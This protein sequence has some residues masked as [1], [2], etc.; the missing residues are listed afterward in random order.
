MDVIIG[1]TA[2]DELIE[3]L[4]ADVTN[5][6]SGRP[7]LDQAFILQEIAERLN[8]AAHDCVMAEC[9]STDEENYIKSI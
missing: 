3:K 5:A 8:G 9:L 4:T 2:M 6:V 1:A 7:W